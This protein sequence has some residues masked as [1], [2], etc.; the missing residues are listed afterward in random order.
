MVKNVIKRDGKI[1]KFEIEKIVKA[2]YKACNDGQIEIHD[3]E[4]LYD[5]IRMNLFNMEEEMTVEEIHDIV[6]KC[7]KEHNEYEVAENY[8]LYRKERNKIR[9]KKSNIMK[10]IIDLGKETDRDNGNVGNNFSAKLLRIASEANKW[11]MLAAMDKEMAKHHE[12]GDYHIHDL[13]SFNLTTNC[14]HAPLG[15]LLKEGFNTGYGTLRTPQRIESAAMLACI[16][17]QSV[18][19]D[20]FGGV[21]LPDFDINLAPYV[22]KTREEERKI[23]ENIEFEGKEE[24]IEKRTVERVAQA[25]QSVICNLNTMH[26]RAG[27]QVP[28]SSLNIGIP[29]GVNEQEKKDSALVCEQIIKAY[30]NGMGK[31]EACIFPNIIFRTKEGVNLN[32]EDPYYYLF[33]LA[34]QSAAKR[35]NPTFCSLDADINLPFYEKGVYTDVMGCRTRVMDNINGEET[36]VGR[37]NI[38]PVTL[39][40]VRM[41]IKAGNGN[42]DKFFEILDYML[43]EAEKNLLYRYDVLK[44]LKVSDL[45]FNAGQHLMVGSEGLNNND[46]IEPIL[47]E[48]TW[49]IGFLGLAECLTMLTGKHHGESKE[50]L[51]LGY[52]IIK[53][54]REYC[55]EAKKRNKL[56]FSCYATPSEGLSG[57][58]PAIDRAKYGIIEGVTDKDYY[59]NSCHV[60]VGFNIS[61]KEKMEIEAMFQPLCNGGH[62][63]YLELDTYPTGKQIEKIISTTFKHN[64]GLD[65]MAINFHIKYC[66]KCGEYLEEHEDVCKCGCDDLQGIS[67]ITGYLA[68]DERFGKGKNAERKDRV[69]HVNGKLVYEKLYRK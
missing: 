39:N 52:R 15:K 37:G 19:N 28:F 50:S 61:M 44:R 59:T 3:E 21:S 67:R 29:D 34:C 62:I 20:Q 5:M 31:N 9:E 53:H 14:L 51:E 12:N 23:L 17:I 64:K 69:S 33:E 4:L 11:A 57:R 46:S 7:L 60:P 56:N 38:A 43:V 22:E 68:L 13:D 63:A 65:Y 66:K 54:I 1:E 49:G 32:P 55:D 42:I 10:T 47:K 16:I 40:L 35:M 36:P 24:H 25:M 30:M 45:P 18:Q 26:S 48:G 2:V 6:I 8:E 27:S 41:A 58:F